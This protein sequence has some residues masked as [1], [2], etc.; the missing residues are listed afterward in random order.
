M[1]N[2]KSQ[3]YRVVSTSS[4]SL[5]ISLGAI[6]LVVLVFLIPSSYFPRIIVYS[7][8][9]S[10]YSIQGFQNQTFI[11]HLTGYETIPFI[12]VNM[13]GFVKF[14][15]EPNLQRNNEIYYEINITGIHEDIL[16]VDV[17]SGDQ[18]LDGPTLVTLYQRTQ[19]ISPNICCKS[20]DAEQ[21]RDRFFFNGTITIQSLQ[22]GPLYEAKNISELLDL[23]NN[24]SAYVEVFRY[25]PD[26][27]NL[28]NMK[29]ELRGQITN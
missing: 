23:F 9:L 7:D 26:S 25:D 11:T 17:H 13:T 1:L 4:Y 14:M 28:F 15:T 21:K 12:S 10:S 8:V 18:N 3:N 29:S 6:I 20:V 2:S 24:R 22:A 16:R 5:F 27:S 19:S